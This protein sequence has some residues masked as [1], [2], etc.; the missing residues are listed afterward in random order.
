MT[1]SDGG[2]RGK[3]SRTRRPAEA[4][5]ENEAEIETEEEP[6]GHVLARVGHFV[7]DLVAT[8]WQRLE[9]KLE[10]TKIA[11]R[12][13]AVRVALVVAAGVVGLV[14]VCASVVALLR[15]AC[16]G[17]AQLFGGREWL[18]DLVGGALALA[19]VA[20]TATLVLRRASRH[21]DER[22]HAKEEQL[23][24]TAH[25]RGASGRSPAAR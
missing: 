1:S 20:G 18:G 17:L 19:L 11:A 9:V 2:A 3:S 21:E 25:P 7:E 12:R 15:G 13:S 4:E 10:R 5:L 14:W 22:L 24:R 23:E 8:G 16:L 6:L